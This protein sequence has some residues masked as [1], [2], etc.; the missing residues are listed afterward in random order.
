M[1]TG[2]LTEKPDEMLSKGLGGGNGGGTCHGRA[3]QPGGE[4]LYF[5]SLHA[6]ETRIGCCWIGILARV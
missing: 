2:E 3:F 1:G 4:L 5:L 6:T